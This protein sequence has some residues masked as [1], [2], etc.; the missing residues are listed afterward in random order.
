MDKS[1][2]EWLNAD[3]T[4]PDYLTMVTVTADGVS[5]QYEF[6][7]P[8]GYLNRADIKAYMF[9]SETAE[10]TDLAVSFVADST[11]KLSPAQPAGARV[12]IYR[13][14]PKSLPL[15]NFLDGAMIEGRNLDRNAKQCIFAIAEILD[16]YNIVYQQVELA[17][18]YAKAAKAS[19]AEATVQALFVESIYNRFKITDDMIAYI[20]QQ[21]ADSKD[22]A[23]YAN[24]QRALAEQFA[25]QAAGYRD[26]AQA[27]ANLK[28]IFPDTAAGVA[29]T[30]VG[31]YF[32]VPQGFGN[33]RSFITYLHKSDGTAEPVASIPGSAFVE[34]TA[35]RVDVN[36]SNIAELNLNF[37]RHSM[38]SA[39]VALH[40]DENGKVPTWLDN[41]NLGFA[42]ITQE[43]AQKVVDSSGSFPPIEMGSALVAL[44]VDEEQKV[45]L[46]LD[47][48]RLDAAGV[49]R[50]LADHA[51]DAST[52]L[53]PKNMSSNLV[54]LTYDEAGKIPLWLDKGLLDAA[55][56]TAH[57]ANL[58]GAYIGGGTGGNTA[59]RFTDGRSLFP[60]RTKIAKLMKENGDVNIMTIGDSWS[61]F[62]NIATAL[63]LRAEKDW[64]V[65]KRGTGWLQLLTEGNSKWQG[66]TVTRSGFTEYDANGVPPYGCGVD[67]LAYYTTTSATAR[68]AGIPDNAGAVHYYD[69]TGSFTLT[70]GSNTQTITGGGTGTYKSAA[71]T[72]LTSGLDT[73]DIVATG[74]VCLHGFR[75]W[76]AGANGPMLFKCGNGGT[77]GGQHTEFITPQAKYFA[78]SI[79]PDII[80]LNLGT[81]DFLQSRSTE[82][83]RTALVGIIREWR[84]LLPN[85]CFLLISPPTPN[86]PGNT[87]MV[88]F[89]NT[90][91][92]VVTEEGV[93][94]YDLYGD[95]PATWDEGNALGW[96]K[97]KYHPNDVGATQIANT[98][99]NKILNS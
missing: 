53:A 31:E 87:P 28:G 69:G 96:W 93:E 56:V 48:G 85:V 49:T 95:S 41:G 65:P 24:V 39:K 19:A 44:H 73:M 17:E 37:E 55:G 88:S 86:A 34:N 15:I 16:K 90:M 61:E 68:I 9:V 10:R 35:A 29:G 72:V 62:F 77:W 52:Y 1:T 13:D 26:Q 30:A 43:A 67:G 59:K 54:A 5:D 99:F 7:F 83:Y 97:D 33:Q 46:W 84:R 21:A 92:D 76:R 42:G 25:A 91:R 64:G 74:Q 70:V 40:V 51:I 79:R 4:E 82:T 14:T 3:S 58:V 71:I 78:D 2:Q 89:R 47:Q 11:V 45:P 32:Q 36:E 66:I 57:F 60:L 94:W 38:H 6:N 81:N 75:L 27:A 22:S 80:V 23:D 50:H 20:E 98:V 63:I 8:G 12:T 18:M